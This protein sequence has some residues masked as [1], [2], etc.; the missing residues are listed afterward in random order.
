M[1]LLSPRLI[2]P[3]SKETWEE[4]TSLAIPK[5]LHVPLGQWS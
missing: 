5:D 1:K 3:V 2:H 4:M